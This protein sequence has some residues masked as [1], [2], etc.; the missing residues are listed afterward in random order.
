M[1]PLPVV[2]RHEVIEGAEQ[3]PLPK[4]DQTIETLLA[5][6]AHEPLRLGVAFGP[7]TG[8]TTNRTPA[9]GTSGIGQRVDVFV[10]HDHDRRDDGRS[11]K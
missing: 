6:G 5:D 8:V 9:S 10:T 11:L 1:V 4:Q 7:W 3:P 2:V